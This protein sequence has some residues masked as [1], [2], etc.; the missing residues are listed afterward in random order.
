MPDKTGVAGLKLLDETL[1]TARRSVSG[2]VWVES[3]GV[4]G[5]LGDAVTGNAKDTVTEGP[6][7][8]DSGIRD[9][10]DGVACEHESSGPDIEGFCTRLQQMDFGSIISGPFFSFALGFAFGTAAT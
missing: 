1:R 3:R 4:A 5:I 7:G 9:G 8:D 2:R 10:G 6:I